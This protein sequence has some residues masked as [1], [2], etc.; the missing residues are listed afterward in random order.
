MN[1]NQ[2]AVDCPTCST[3]VTATYEVIGVE[4]IDGQ[5]HARIQITMP[6]HNMET[7]HEHH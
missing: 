6:L 4:I 1:H 5:P 7:P 2:I 3:I